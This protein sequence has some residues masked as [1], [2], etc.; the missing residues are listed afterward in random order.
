VPTLLYFP[1]R[2]W[3]PGESGYGNGG[4]VSW[5]VAT[6]LG[7]LGGVVV[8]GFSLAGRLTTT[9][10]WPWRSRRQIAPMVVA[11]GL[12]LCGSAILPGVVA[13]DGRTT[14]PLALFMLGAGAPLFIARAARGAQALL[15]DKPGPDDIRERRSGGTSG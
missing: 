3:Q 15:E 10:R 5:Q 1:V 12:R 7:L 4:L 11:W 8:E 2:Y 14:S 13:L 6:L 9:K